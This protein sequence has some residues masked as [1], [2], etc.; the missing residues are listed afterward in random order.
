MYGYV[1]MG[2]QAA[3]AVR[4]IGGIWFLAAVVP[5][6]GGL[7][8]L[9]RRRLLRRLNREK[10][11]RC[12]LPPVLAEEAARYG[13]YHIRVQDLRLAMLPQLL[14]LWGDL[15]RE[16]AALRAEY[17]SPA[18]YQA[19]EILARRVRYLSLEVDA[20]GDMLAQVLRQRFGL[21]TGGGGSPAVTVSFGG[22][23]PDNAICLGEDCCRYQR[24]TYE[25]MPPLLEP[26]PPSEQLLAVLFEAGAIKKEQLYVKTISRS[27]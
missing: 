26:W 24:V 23:P 5:Q 25:L 15:R 14:T 4:Q 20:G 17:A 12:V 18:V 6:G 9:R 16:S 27:A 22:T 2:S 7:A 3:L 19:A 11:T 10:I 21:S 13:L 1:E 8:K